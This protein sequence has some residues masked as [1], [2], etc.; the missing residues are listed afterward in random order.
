M[1]KDRFRRRSDYSGPVRRP[2]APA[3]IVDGIDQTRPMVQS[4]PAAATQPEQIQQTRIAN[5][6]Y[7]QQPPTATPQ[8]QSEQTPPQRQWT[9]PA[10]SQ[11]Q[12]A[13]QGGGTA[14]ETPTTIAVNISLPKLSK[15][16][17]KLP[18]PSKK[19]IKIFVI[20]LVVIVLVGAAVFA[21]TK[22]LHR[23]PQVATTA[24]ASLKTATASSPSYTPVVPEN[25][26]ELA[27]TKTAGTGFDGSRD[28]YSYQDSISGLAFTVSQQ[29]MPTG[30]STPQA[31]I[32]KIAKAIGGTTVV[33]IPNGTKGYISGD[34]KS[35]NQV[36]VFTLHNLLV[37][38]QS[39]FSHTPS[40]WELYI[41]TLK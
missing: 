38:I 10:S 8:P 7:Q 37:F 33:K 32:D 9:P 16:K 30:N 12:P 19:T 4:Q 22:F 21:T 13:T 25:K 40:D 41:A 35:G 18:K 20:V 23:T 39:P 27:S 26:T 11:S 5:D 17:V 34:V 14:S 6:A 31:K 28:T 1:D 15:P 29:P 24:G 2:V 3:P 36:I